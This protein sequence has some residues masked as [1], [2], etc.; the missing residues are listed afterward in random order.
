MEHIKDRS[1]PLYVN[2]IRKLSP[3]TPASSCFHKTTPTKQNRRNKTRNLPPAASGGFCFPKWSKP[4]WNL[5]RKRFWFPQKGS[6]QTKTYKKLFWFSKKGSSQTTPKSVFV[7]T[8]KAVEPNQTKS[9]FALPQRA[10]AKMT[11][12]QAVFVFQKGSWNLERSRWLAI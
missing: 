6:S 2:E 12:R 10:R 1:Q 3:A 7:C 8:Q 5:V 4:I 11:S 9:G